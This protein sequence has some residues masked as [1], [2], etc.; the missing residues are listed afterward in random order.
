[1][2]ARGL[3]NTHQRI[4]TAVTVDI[5]GLEAVDGIGQPPVA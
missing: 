4:D 2:E 5:A 3:D 1:M